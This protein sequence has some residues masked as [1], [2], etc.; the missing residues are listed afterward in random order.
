MRL[1]DSIYVA[2]VAVTAYIIATIFVFTQCVNQQHPPP[3]GN[4]SE[5]ATALR[6]FPVSSAQ[7]SDKT[8][9]EEYFK[10]RFLEEVQNLVNG[11][12]TEFVTKMKMVQSQMVTNEIEI[13]LRAEKENFE[14]K[15]LS[16]Q[17]SNQQQ[18]LDMK[19]LYEKQGKNNLLFPK[20]RVGNYFANMARV[21]R[22][23]FNHTFSSQFGYEFLTSYSGSKDLLL[24]YSSDGATANNFSS[25][26]GNGSD[27]VGV[28]FIEDAAVATEN[29]DELRVVFIGLGLP[30]IRQC[31]ALVPNLES[32]HVHPLVRPSRFE[33]PP[34]R[35]K[36]IINRTEPFLFKS[37]YYRMDIP[38]DGSLRRPP[39]FEQESK[40]FLKYLQKYLL[41]VDTVLEELRTI[42][43][44][45]AIDNQ[46]I[47]MFCNYGQAVLLNNFIC[48]AQARN[49]N[50]SNLIVFTTDQET[51]DL[52]TSYGLTAYYDQ[53]VSVYYLSKNFA[54]PLITQL[55]QSPSLT[56]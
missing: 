50:L 31:L 19:K 11:N 48:T 3:T 39:R 18:I 7:L 14:T 17:A 29:C 21:S 5:I 28:P 34:S 43:S 41:A 22:D 13:Q 46:V 24:L 44:K 38:T 45:I 35:D 12:E 16:I 30:K 55:N 53:G 26:T 47:V 33:N 32:F 36:L 1:Y 9:L 4:D 40:P 23:S 8:I 52:V 15:L 27:G 20:D 51:T 6:S 42:L 56:I 10:V 54:A 2:I 37:R 25:Y 49:I